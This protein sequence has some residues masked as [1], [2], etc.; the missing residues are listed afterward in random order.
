[1]NKPKYAKIILCC[2]ISTIGVWYA[3]AK[4]QPVLGAKS[5]TSAVGRDN[6]FAG[7]PRVVKAASPS[8]L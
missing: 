5:K 3:L 1:M 7:I 8:V 4:S 6:P 2:V